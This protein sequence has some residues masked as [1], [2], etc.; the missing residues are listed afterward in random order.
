MSG[1]TP[2]FQYGQRVRLPDKTGIVTVKIQT[3]SGGNTVLGVTDPDGKW[4]EL[5]LTVEELRRVRVAT[6][7][8][9]ASP[10]MVLAGLWAERMVAS[11][12]SATSTVLASSRLRPYPHQMSAVYGQMLPQSKLRF[13]L[14]DEPGTGKTIMSGLWLREAQRLGLVKRAL[15]VCPAHLV[16]KWRADFDRFFGGGLQEVT[17]ETV[18]QGTLSISNHAIWVVS[19]HRAAKNPT[20][21]EGIRPVNGG[22]DAVIFDEAHR[23]TPTAETF[24]NVGK[25]LMKVPH[26]LFLTATPHRG[27]EWLFQDLL[28][29]VD[30][31]LF[32]EV[33]PPARG[34]QP[35][36]TARRK[37]K[38]GPVH[39][40]RRMKEPLVDYDRTRKLFKPR[41]AKN[42]KVFL[43][44]EEQ[45]FHDRAIA[46]VR[47]FFPP[48]ARSLAGL[49][50]GKRAASSLHAL[51]RTLHRRSE[52]MGT[53]PTAPVGDNWY[54]EGAEDGGEGRVEGVRSVDAKAEREAIRGML[55]ELEPLLG[56]EL[57]VSKWAPMIDHCLTPHGITPDGDRQ[58]VVFTEYADTAGWLVKR[59]QD[60]GFPSRRYSGDENHLTRAQT[61]ADFQ[62]G[63]FQVLVSTDAGNEGIDLQSANVLVNWDM[64]WSLVR[65][66]QRLGRIHRIGQQRK[67]WFYNLVALGT[68]ES[69][70]H[71]TLLDNLVN[72]ANQLDGRIF[73]SLNAVMERLDITSC[74]DPPV[75]PGG[76]VASETDI[77]RVFNEIRSE[78]EYLESGID[79]DL[80]QSARRSELL[81]RIE[82]D[83]VERFL[84]RLVAA[85]LVTRDPVPL[86]DRGFYYLSSVGWKLPRNL[87]TETGGRTLV[88]TR[89]A[90]RQE[91]VEGG[92]QRAA[93]A[94]LLTPSRPLFYQL[95]QA[96]RD[97]T[98]AAMWQGAALSDPSAQQDY[99]LFVYETTLEVGNGGTEVKVSWLIGVDQHGKANRV[100]WETLPNLAPPSEPASRPL[101]AQAEASAAAHADHLAAAETK[102]RKSAA[103]K[104]A[105]GLKRELRDLPNVT[106]EHIPDLQTRIRERQRLE[107]NVQTRINQAQQQAEI[108]HTRPR[109]LGWAHVIADQQIVEDPDSEDVS[110]R[111]VTRLLEQEHFI[112]DDVSGENIGFDLLAERGADQRCV[113]VKG[114]RGSAS[115]KGIELTGGE[116]EA[117]RTMG[118]EYWLYVV[119]HCEDG[120][121]RLFSAWQNPERVFR[122]DFKPVPAVRL[123][124]S[125][126]EA[127]RNRKGH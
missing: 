98:E 102:Q 67:A 69:Q 47:E 55:D 56:P 46:L 41:Q 26:A 111:H 31:E 39:F 7:D 48:E 89:E 2:E 20:V 42:V 52:K 43:N 68:R 115:S 30:P 80:A 27:K 72:A 83:T 9:A 10:E 54:D 8:G 107:A 4:R 118:E 13:L 19:M 123:P 122:D 120:I 6:E 96:I 53:D 119:D 34:R 28:H 3:P 113:E 51:S 50:Y 63:D 33:E 17:L 36:R 58:V 38:P 84:D 44:G 12:R 109:R 100:A 112:V 97:R 108:T 23:M 21:L 49:V 45:D 62:K 79:L 101:D 78:A 103:E 75:V 81:Q 73:D 60:A 32:P 90:L 11:V 61:Q 59:F 117:A 71:E 86:A 127:A 106:T 94:T 77:V 57:E 35:R 76:R 124:G 1:N 70:A 110:M 16:Q 91:L 104:W 92:K 37:L 87:P 29:L 95:T 93:K 64:P 74:F 5:I 22:W 116:L 121:G 14:A 65:L 18:Q 126:L 99:T 88:T 114:R 105:T 66:E 85:G 82:P 25:A 15:V 125:A 40:L 24:H